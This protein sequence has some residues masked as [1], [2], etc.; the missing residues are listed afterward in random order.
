MTDDDY[1]ILVRE[2]N[3][4]LKNSGWTPTFYVWAQLGIA[5]SK[6]QE[7]RDQPVWGIREG[8]MQPRP[9]GSPLRDMMV[10]KQAVTLVANA[11]AFHPLATPIRDVTYDEAIALHKLKN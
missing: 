3:K 10:A 11:W 8:Y 4:T 5:I 7:A 1:N 2:I 6:R 9:Q